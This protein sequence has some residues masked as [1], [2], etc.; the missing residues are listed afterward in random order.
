IKAYFL[1]LRNQRAAKNNP[2][3]RYSVSYEKARA[4]GILFSDM[5]DDHQAINKFVKRL[6]D[7][8]KR[9]K[10]LTYFEQMHSNGYDFNFDYFTRE[11]ITTTGKI[12]SDKVDQFIDSDFD[13]LFCITRDSFL[14][15]DYILL[16]S[17][18]KCRIGMYLDD[19]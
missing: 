6:K 4:V 18:A 8:G 12:T 15:F 19:K 17:K 10:A 9:V 5:A 7:E 11:Q 3:K 16:K 1:A 14:P 2:V 13:H